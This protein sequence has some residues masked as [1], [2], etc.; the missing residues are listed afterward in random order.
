MVFLNGV[1]YASRQMIIENIENFTMVG[2]G[3]FTLGLEDL[4]EASSKIECVGT[5]RSGFN[6]T[7]VTGLHIENLT[8]TYSSQ[9]VV[10]TV[11]AAL[12]FAM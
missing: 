3:G 12:A 5:R 1:H 10:F 4:P 2:S 9:E 8:F 11:R 7:N 6:F